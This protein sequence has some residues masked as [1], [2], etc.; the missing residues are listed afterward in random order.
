MGSLSRNVG[1]W[2]R[3]V[4]LDNR[5]R[6]AAGNSDSLMH[7]ELSAI[8]EIQHRNMLSTQQDLE[9]LAYVQKRAA[10]RNLDMLWRLSQLQR[11]SV[12]ELTQVNTSLAQVNI[13]LQSANDAL[14][15]ISSHLEDVYRLLSDI[16]DVA[17]EQS[18]VVKAERLLKESLFQ[19]QL[20]IEEMI[21]PDDEIARCLLSEVA[22]AKL[23]SLGLG[24]AALSDLG[25]KR[26]FATFV[27]S[28]RK[29]ARDVSH[30]AHADKLVFEMAYKRYKELVESGFAAFVESDPFP[31]FKPSADFPALEPAPAFPAFVP[32]A[33]FPE[34]KPDLDWG[35]FVPNAPPKWV[36]KPEPFWHPFS[37]PRPVLRTARPRPVAVP[38]PGEHPL[39]R[40]FEDLPSFEPAEPHRNTYNGI[41]RYR[42]LD[43]T[44]S[45]CP[46]ENPADHVR[47]PTEEETNARWPPLKRL[48]F[49]LFGDHGYHIGDRFVEFKPKE[50]DNARR[51]EAALRVWAAQR[52]RHEVYLQDIA[53]YELECEAVRVENEQIVNVVFPE[54]LKVFHEDEQKRYEQW[55]ADCEKHQAEEVVRRA[56]W[57]NE[58]ARHRKDEDRRHKDW[59]EARVRHI[60]IEKE[61]LA[62]WEL[63]KAKYLEAERARQS[64]WKKEERECSEQERKRREAWEVAKAEYAEAERAR[65][66]DWEEDKKK[67]LEAENQRRQE[68]EEQMEVF[69][70]GIGERAEFINGFLDEHPDV[71]LVYRKVDGITKEKRQ[72]KTYKDR[73][74]DLF[75][76]RGVV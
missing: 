27:K 5:F 63:E 10:E 37:E 12:A 58:C 56:E 69:N 22:L 51:Y 7:A 21:Q 17:S 32:A 16:R 59:D 4:L 14:V 13:S 75:N 74:K 68:W 45:H 42:Y 19:L 38:H 43:I 11:E 20:M 6:G 23:D 62:S 8:A 73:I 61:R 50:V 48:I 31:E 60:A 65:Y 55:Q 66:L 9:H 15:A 44:A 54:Q 39:P 76:D 1:V 34:F 64:A 28:I 71:Q 35:A 52:T 26:E 33:D 70:K 36:A 53:Q 47:I 24:T 25:D 67:Y 57:E 3:Q 41:E 40:Q 49:G 18:R 30:E 46:S 29:N 2:Q 72:R